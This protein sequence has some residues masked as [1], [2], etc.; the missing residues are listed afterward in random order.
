MF[1]SG[2]IALR[3]RRLGLAAVGLIALA[4]VLPGSA[5]AAV[6][7]PTIT[8]QFT[9]SSIPAGATTALSFTIANPNASG[10]LTGIAF[11]DTLPN[12]VVIDTPNGQNGT[13]GSNGVVT[14]VGG[15]STISLTGGKVAAG[16]NCVV[17]VSVTSTTPGGYQNTTG[18]VASTEGGSGTA[19][20]QTLTVFG[21]PTL[22]VTAPRE[23]AT[24]D[25]GQRVIARYSCRDAPGAPGI[26]A[27]SGDADSGAPIDT[28]TVGPNTFSV[29]AI[30]ADGAVTTQTID[31]TVR[32]D[33]RFTVSKIKP[34]ANGQVSFTAKVPGAGKLVATLSRGHTRLGQVKL[35]LDSDGSSAV[36][37]KPG[38]ALRRLL[39]R[40]AQSTHPRGRPATV[41]VAL[42][43]TYTPT[44]GK[45]RTETFRGIALKP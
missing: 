11:T 34:H 15:S 35:T 28:S 29:S 37:V 10:N 6:N 22:T 12:G 33:N 4:G 31:Y 2:R 44:G 19:D 20:T 38:P 32:P 40:A 45:P 30:S 24:Y 7:P 16:A 26:S 41:V 1:S 25:F 43:V 27:C 9:P 36:V 18:P 3:P 8:S 23:G 5:A 39:Q 42:T 13:C 14:A 17:Q 21:L